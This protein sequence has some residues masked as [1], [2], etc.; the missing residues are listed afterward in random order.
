MVTSF[1]L[2]LSGS[3]YQKTSHTSWGVASSTIS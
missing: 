3:R 2:G 1:G